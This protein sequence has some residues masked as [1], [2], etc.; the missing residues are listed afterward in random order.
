MNVSFMCRPQRSNAA[1]LL[2]SAAMRSITARPLRKTAL[3]HGFGDAVL[4]DLDRAAGDHPA[5][6]AAQAVFDQLFLA[7]AEPAHD[8]QRL[9]RH[10]E[11][12]LVAERLRDR[13]FLRRRKPAVGVG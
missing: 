8:L 10:V 4:E 12:G 2:A 13:R 7:V 3:E 6:A 9:A 11:A 5:A 1:S